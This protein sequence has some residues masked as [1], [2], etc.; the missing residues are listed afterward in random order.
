VVVEADDGNEEEGEGPDDAFQYDGQP[1]SAAD[2]EAVGV[3]DLLG[4]NEGV[5]GPGVKGRGD[6]HRDKVCPCEGAIKRGG[7]HGQA[8][9]DID[10]APTIEEE[11]K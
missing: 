11:C 5:D 4:D 9:E 8:G 3:M 7:D 1:G 10:G 6:A 2:G